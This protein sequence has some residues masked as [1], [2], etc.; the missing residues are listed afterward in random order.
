MQLVGVS[1]VLG[2]GLGR[3][4]DTWTRGGRGK[5]GQG[6][7]VE[8]EDKA[9]RTDTRWARRSW[10]SRGIRARRR[11]LV[12]HELWPIIGLVRGE[13]PVQEMQRELRVVS[14]EQR[15]VRRPAMRLRARPR[16]RRSARGVSGRSGRDG[17]DAGPHV[18]SA[19]VT[20]L[21]RT[22]LATPCVGP[23]AAF[24]VFLATFTVFTRSNSSRGT[25]SRCIRA[26]RGRTGRLRRGR[27]VAGAT[28][29]V[30]P[31]PGKAGPWSW[32]DAVERTP[33]LLEVIG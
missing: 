8:E 21:P 24:E 33:L 1:T 7:G 30:A 19:S 17:A 3:T 23:W 27:S 10:D 2:Q 5:D 25:L 12:Q 29:P 32:L 31:S 11:T 14:I 28:R 13:Q 9:R 26:A 4:K 15:Q 22:A 18:A 6:Q 16:A 20:G